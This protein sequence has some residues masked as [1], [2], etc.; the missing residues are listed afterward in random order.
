MIPPEGSTCPPESSGSAQKRPAHSGGSLGSIL[1]WASVGADV[2]A[3]EE[4]RL[5]RHDVDDLQLVGGVEDPDP[6]RVARA[7]ADH[8]VV[9]PVAVV[10]GGGD[11][12]PALNDAGDRVVELEPAE[13][14]GNQRA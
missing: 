13:R 9:Q 8:D 10:V 5:V 3:A 1:D 6:R 7:A 14:V 4:V 11:A 12:D 2:D